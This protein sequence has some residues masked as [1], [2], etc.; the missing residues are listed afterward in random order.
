MALSFEDMLVANMQ[1]FRELENSAPPVGLSKEG[2]MEFLQ[3]RAAQNAEIME[4]NIVIINNHL[5][6]L[7]KNP[8]NIA[9][10]QADTLFEL[11]KKLFALEVSLD[12]SLA[13]EIHKALIANAKHNNDIDR[14]VRSQYF[15]GI[16]LQHFNRYLSQR[17]N[18][19]NFALNAA[20]YF[21]DAAVHRHN[22]QNIDNKETRMYINRCL[23]NIYV[24]TAVLRHNWE[25][26]EASE[27]FF[28]AVDTAIDFWNRED[29]RAVDPD[30]PWEMFITNAHQNVC[31]WLD[32][33]RSKKRQERNGELAKRI[34]DSFEYMS[35]PNAVVNINRFWS[36]IRTQYVSAATKYFVDKIDLN[37]ML[38]V[39]HQIHYKS[40][41]G[42]Y[43]SNGQFTMI[44]MGMALI[45]HLKELGDDTEGER[46][47]I[48]KRIF[49]YFENAPSGIDR[50]ELNGYLSMLALGFGREKNIGT[51]E[52]IS[53]L[54]RFSS[55][56][57]MT[58][59][60]H[61]VQVKDLT[62]IVTEHF[63]NTEP[64]LFIGALGKQNVDEILS[65]KTEILEAACR[66]A[67]C[68]DIGKIYYYDT[69][70]LCARKLYD[71]EFDT[72]K[73][74]VHPHQLLE[75]G[76]DE[77]MQCILDAIQGHHRYY[78]G[79]GG[80]PIWF[81]NATSANKFIIDI[82]SI[83]DSVDAATDAIGRSHTKILTLDKVIKE[84]NDQAGTRYNPII[85]KALYN[86]LI[87]AKIS[88]CI[89]MGRRNAYYE[90]YLSITK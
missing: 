43:S 6:P 67:L 66:A 18:S 41:Y 38:D 44:S 27:I 37:E 71:Y 3:M 12:G 85:A 87:R 74:H 60:T 54:L 19:E 59:Y 48:I 13:F 11:A 82:V 5:T 23:G 49:N 68:H 33:L 25:Y 73:E 57:H 78:D 81:D 51:Q 34:Y 58:T 47:E 15:A 22:Y 70:S 69:I 10:A 21:E 2:L 8:H 55:Y 40:K 83:C 79:V 39:L 29:I 84:I 53:L 72:I 9:I 64:E 28:N 56:S 32:M 80:Y 75:K 65:S 61:S 36:E 26:K 52:Y 4:D 17:A 77:L 31:G 46:N 88:R 63:L 62:A 30:F 7:L 24:A 20:K 90:A 16:I 89:T 86:P 14:A 1:E 76:D 50:Q 35:K 45:S 42:D